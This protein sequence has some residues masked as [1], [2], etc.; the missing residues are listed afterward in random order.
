MRFGFA[1]GY[2]LPI[3]GTGLGEEYFLD[4]Y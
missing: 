1:A 3:N 4:E 2:I